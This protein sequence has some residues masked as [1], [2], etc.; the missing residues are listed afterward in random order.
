M[1]RIVL[2][3]IVFCFL[4][5]T[6]GAAWKQD[7]FMIGA[8]HEL[9]FLGNAS[10]DRIA[11]Q[12]YKNLGFNILI[13]SIY[14]KTQNIWKN[15]YVFFHTIDSAF[16]PRIDAQYRL[17]IV[18]SV[19]GMKTFV[20]DRDLQICLTDVGKH[21]FDDCHDHAATMTNHYTAIT[22][23]YTRQFRDNMVGFFGFP[24]EA[25]Y[26]T[27]VDSFYPVMEQIKS[28]APDKT[29]LVN[30]CGSLGDLWRNDGQDELKNQ[31]K[32]L[33]S[34]S[35]HLQDYLQQPF[36]DL[37]SFDCYKFFCYYKN[38]PSF[39]VND[40]PV[41]G[42]S[43]RQ[44][45]FAHLNAIITAVNNANKVYWGAPCCAQHEIEEWSRK[46]ASGAFTS[47]DRKRKAPLNPSD[48]H[49]AKTG[50]YLRH[51]ADS[52]ILYGAKG[53]LW[54][55]YNPAWLNGQNQYDF[56]A[57]P[58]KAYP[59]TPYFGTRE[60]YIA[61]PA[62]NAAIRDTVQ[63]INLE[64]ARL[65]PL[66]MQLKWITTVHGADKAPEIGEAFLPT[67]ASMDSSLPCLFQNASLNVYAI[68]KSSAAS[69]HWKPDSMAIGIFQN[70]GF[71]YLACMNKSLS[72]GNS[73]TYTTHGDFYPR[74]FDKT[75]GG[76]K[77]MART[78]DKTKGA[79]GATRFELTISP[80]DLQLV[81]LGP[82]DTTR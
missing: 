77:A 54:Y 13:G 46:D 7:Q 68:G 37:F 22:P 25:P 66:L 79:D 59:F 6:A 36:T 75:N 39:D 14:E 65:G 69:S 12:N 1:K 30:F 61:Y 15:G 76:W 8:F 50:P 38:P 47:L 72:N 49:N 74:V 27:V 19:P 41:T 5:N 26:S 81:W 34:F 60:I 42:G 63:R 62:N 73:S 80:G 78:F 4:A 44:T 52:Y 57:N 23:A 35:A 24:D 20:Y 18:S 56:A 40:G 51:E 58:V 31:Q 71:Q 32:F 67:P 28:A 29:C 17:G 64:I 2:Y 21:R 53:L 9:T 3:S 70:N 48:P 43:P 82:A 55:S 11:L 10:E 33:N 45:F 16:L